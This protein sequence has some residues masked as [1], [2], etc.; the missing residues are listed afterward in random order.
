[1]HP[2]SEVQEA[3]GTPLPI[4]RSPRVAAPNVA[5]EPT[6]MAGMAGAGCGVPRNGSVEGPAAGVA[7][8]RPP[9]EPWRWGS[10]WE[11]T[12]ALASTG[13]FSDAS[14]TDMVATST[15]VTLKRT[16]AVKLEK[17][18]KRAGLPLDEYLDRALKQ[19][20]ENVE[21][22]MAA[23]ERG[24]ADIRE[25]RFRSLDDAEAEPKRRRNARAR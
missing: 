8:A 2:W 11:G 15:T 20:V 12:A 16:R 17:L 9:P 19:H 13:A 21:R 24:R 10:S 7:H 4:T 3:P 1:M 18:A 14:I 22:V 5:D 23:V 25:G 6:R